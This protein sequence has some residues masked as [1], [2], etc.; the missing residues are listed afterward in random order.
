MSIQSS[1][2]L[3]STGIQNTKMT[4]TI[5]IAKLKRIINKCKWKGKV[6]PSIYYEQL[7]HNRALEILEKEL[8]RLK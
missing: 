1:T 8:A 7:Y 6:D 2:I 3:H 4:E 5:T